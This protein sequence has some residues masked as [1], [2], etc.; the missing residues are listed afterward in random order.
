VDK[1]SIRGSK[2][3]R[4]GYGIM[5][6]H[7]L[8]FRHCC[9]GNSIH[10]KGLPKLRLLGQ[11]THIHPPPLPGTRGVEPAET[12]GAGEWNR[13]KLNGDGLAR[14]VR[15]SSGLSSLERKDADQLKGWSP[16]LSFKSI[17]R[18]S[19]SVTCPEILS[20]FVEFVATLLRSRHMHYTMN[21]AH[22]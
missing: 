19:A 22:W 10:A 20:L 14:F 9:I 18:R 2:Q 8:F 11:A 1:S 17:R 12:H 4:R 21:I 5:S 13:A 7:R 16:S 15:W 3:E 6:D